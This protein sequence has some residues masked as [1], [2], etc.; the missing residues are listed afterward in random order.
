[1]KNICSRL[2]ISRRRSTR[3][4]YVRDNVI[5]SQAYES[6]DRRPDAKDLRGQITALHTKEAGQTDK[7][8]APDATDKYHVPVWSDLLFR[9]K[10]LGFFLVR[11]GIENSAI[12]KELAWSVTVESVRVQPKIIE[13]MKRPP[14][15]LPQNVM[16]QCRSI[17]HIDSRRWRTDT[18]VYCPPS[19]KCFS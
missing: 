2:V 11:S 17:F 4:A 8:V 18:V 14:A 6:E 9:R 7:P 12:W 19:V 3:H 16:N 1:M 5:K 10:G 15:R 13:T